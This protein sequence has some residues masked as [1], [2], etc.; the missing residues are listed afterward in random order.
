M[1]FL[2]FLSPAVSDLSA[3]AGER[4][5]HLEVPAAS[6][7]PGHSED[8]ERRGKTLQINSTNYTAICGV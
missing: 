7:S 5:A 3:A 1:Y 2:F 8:R 4:R 6:V